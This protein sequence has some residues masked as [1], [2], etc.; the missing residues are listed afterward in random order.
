[1]LIFLQVASS[2]SVFTIG[3]VRWF[4]SLARFVFS[5]DGVMRSEGSVVPCSVVSV[6]FCKT[7]SSFSWVSWVWETDAVSASIKGLVSCASSG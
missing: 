5:I 7:D 4:Q 3:E 2:C 1:M 6:P